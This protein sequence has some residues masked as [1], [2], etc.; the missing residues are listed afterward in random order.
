MHEAA[1]TGEVIQTDTQT[2]THTLVIQTWRY[3]TKHFGNVD[4]ESNMVELII[5]AWNIQHGWQG[6]DGRVGYC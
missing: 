6:D 2:H 1:F 3:N 5:N 4:T